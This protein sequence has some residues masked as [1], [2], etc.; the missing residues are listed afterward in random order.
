MITG[1]F[2]VVGSGFV[3]VTT[4]AHPHRGHLHATGVGD[5]VEPGGHVPPQMVNGH[6]MGWEQV[7]VGVGSGVLVSS[8]TQVHKGQLHGRG[9]STG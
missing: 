5:G 9:I 8:G 1:G 2:V 6:M 3:V 4:G 7:T